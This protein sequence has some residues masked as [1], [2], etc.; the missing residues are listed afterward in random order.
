VERNWG[1]PIP[2]E[3]TTT[4]TTTTTTST[5]PTGTPK[6][7]PT[8]PGLIESCTSFYKAVSGDT[9]D[10]IVAKYGTF[11]LATFKE[12]NPAVGS[13]CR[14]LWAE[15]YYC[16]GIPGA[17]TSRPSTTQSTTTTGVPK[18][19]PTQPGLIDSCVRFYKAVS[20]DTC[21]AIVARYGTFTLAQFKTWNPAV[22]SD[23]RSLWAETYYCVGIP[24]TPTTTTR[25]TSTTTRG[26][27]IAT[28]SPTQQTI[29][30]NCNKFYLVK[31]NEGCQQVASKNGIPLARFNEWNPSVGSTCSGLWANA[32]ACVS[33]IGYTAPLTTS[34]ASTGK[35][36]G[37]NK[38]AALSSVISW[39]DGS[40][41]TDGIG[42]YNIGQTKNGC[43]NAPL[44]TNKFT[45]SARNDFG[46]T[47]SLPTNTCERIIRSLVNSCDR[48]GTGTLES[49]YFKAVV[50]D[51]RC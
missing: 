17:P 50:V 35:T 7:S 32:Y 24:G 26:T 2:D 44:G 8:Q 4:T 6:P 21:D 40:S 20:G 11:S 47:A 15:T 18:P 19:S 9:C 33:I 49:W 38:N 29:V 5:R 45:F 27:G 13:E 12:W 3:P 23:C 46:V 34:C 22:G 10:G 1:E 51:G 42:N 36:W 14:S 41:S 25:P 31:P 39:C 37:D 16:V 48:G 43:Y 28:P 30:S